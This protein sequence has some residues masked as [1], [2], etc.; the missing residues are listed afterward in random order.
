MSE[1]TIENLEIEYKTLLKEGIE[2]LKSS[3]TAVSRLEQDGDSGHAT[4][5][6]RPGSKQDIV[7]LTEIFKDKQGLDLTGQSY[8][9][10]IQNL[11][12]GKYRNKHVQVL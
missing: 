5:L 10:I 6:V 3:K 4:N 11:C 2:N 7:E 9:Q 8:D 12:A 1:D